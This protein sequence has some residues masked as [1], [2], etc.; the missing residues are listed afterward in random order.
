MSGPATG[1]R[2]VDRALSV[3]YRR[4]SPSQR[5]VIDHL[6]GDMRYAAVISGPELARTLGVSESTVTRAAQTLGFGGYPDLQAHLRDLFVGG[7]SERVAIALDEFGSSPV[8]AAI[9]V[10]LEDAE[11]VRQTA[12]D[13]VAPDLEAALGVLADA[14]S[15]YVFGSRGSFGLALM[16][17]IGLRLILPD[18]R[19]LNQTAGDLADQLISLESYDALVAMSLRRVDRVTVDVLR[20]ARRT[21]ARILVITDHRSSVITRL[22]D[23]P[24]IV[25]SSPL[26]LTASYAAAASLVNALLTGASLHLRS[27]TNVNLE[28]AERLW[29]EF[30]T[31]QTDAGTALENERG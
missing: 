13:L 2:E 5:R 19:V 22:A 26:R 11:R 15:V 25:R 16:L 23:I 21:G 4:L 29:Q 1:I 24:L 31:L 9:R 7:V 8:E 20:H 14:Q 30:A 12:E 3:N 27:D 6:I 10:M 18:V 17:G 28:R